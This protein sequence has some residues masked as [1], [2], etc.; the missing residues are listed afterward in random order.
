MIELGL[1]VKR[2]KIELHGT[3]LCGWFIPYNHATVL[4][5]LRL[6][7]VRQRFDQLKLG[8]DYSVWRRKQRLILV[9]RLD[10][11]NPYKPVAFLRLESQGDRTELK[12]KLVPPAVLLILAW[13]LAGAVPAARFSNWGAIS[14][15]ALAAL[16]AHT[17][18]SRYFRQEQREI[19]DD[20]AGVIGDVL[21]VE[22][23][24]RPAATDVVR[25]NAE[26]RR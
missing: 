8:G 10:S 11:R 12:I 1:S 20:I 13:F 3:G 23:R 7:S 26:E 15:L 4:L 5:N 21:V 9:A 17:F 2:P 24:G 19:T 6:D 16:P 18:F 25:M 22:P 14:V